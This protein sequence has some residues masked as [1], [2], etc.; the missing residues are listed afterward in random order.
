VDQFGQALSVQP[1]F[2][3]GVSGGGTISGGGLFTAGGVA[4]GPHTVTA[5]SGGLNGTASVTVSSAPSGLVAAY[6]FNEASGSGVTDSSGLGNNGTLSGATR[7]TAGKFGRALSFDGT[8]D[9]VNIAD[10][11]SLDL[12]NGMT[13]EAWVR[14]SSLGG[15]DTVILKEQPGSLIYALYANT[16]PGPA[17]G[18]IDTTGG[19]FPQYATGALALNTWSH[20]AATYDGTTLRLYINGIE[21]GSQPVSGSLHTSSGS[22]RIGGNAVWGEYFAGLIDEIR[23]YNRALSQTEIQQDMNAAIN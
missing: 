11:S 5:S 22:L 13:L 18:E 12:T 19:Y 3:W 8:N 16:G 21:V 14:P 6:G 7:T 17:S 15:W 23:I 4:G 9:R 1:G 10:S 2:S 20:L